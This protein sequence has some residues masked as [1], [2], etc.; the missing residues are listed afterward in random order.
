MMS[1][2]RACA[3]ISVGEGVMMREV[4]LDRGR[5]ERALEGRFSRRRMGCRRRAQQRS[6]QSASSRVS[7]GWQ[8]PGWMWCGL[9]RGW[10]LCFVHTVCLCVQSLCARASFSSTVRLNLLTR[11]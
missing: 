6:P 9:V 2:K 5:E 11:C 10:R 1:D 3:W 7:E 4:A 8:R